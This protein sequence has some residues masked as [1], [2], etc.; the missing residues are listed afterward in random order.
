M[1]S[2]ESSANID[3]SNIFPLTIEWSEI[4][5]RL[6]YACAL[7]IIIQI[8]KD[9]KEKSFV[10]KINMYCVMLTIFSYLKNT[11]LIFFLFVFI[12]LFDIV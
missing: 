9:I 10:Y 5:R 1:F 3:I 7:Q 11:N 8:R 6:R 2:F 12:E 4:E